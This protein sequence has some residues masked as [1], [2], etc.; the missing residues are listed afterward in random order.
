MTFKPPGTFFLFS[1]FTLLVLAGLLPFWGL[2]HIPKVV[3]LDMHSRTGE[4]MS[5]L[6]FSLFGLE[7]NSSWCFAGRLGEGA[8]PAL[9][10]GV[11]SGGHRVLPPPAVPLPSAAWRP[12]PGPV[13]LP[14]GAFTNAGIFNE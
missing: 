9:P 10:G 5:S 7:V 11:L 3:K 2:Y 8:L 1:F 12:G 14:E 13:R 4:L 6:V